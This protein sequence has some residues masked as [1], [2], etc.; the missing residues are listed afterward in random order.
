MFNLI[1]SGMLK[2]GNAI[3]STSKYEICKIKYEFR[4]REKNA[5]NM[6][7]PGLMNEVRSLS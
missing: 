4:R 2:L 5:D 3:G 6:L 7:T 1:E